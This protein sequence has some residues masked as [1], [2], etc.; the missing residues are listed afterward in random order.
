[1]TAP[2]VYLLAGEPS[3]DRLGAALI[4]GLRAEAPEVRIAG[5]GGREM[6]AA[7]L[8]TLFD[9]ADL[10]V[11]GYAE[12]LPRLPLILRRLRAATADVLARRPA[13]LV[14]IDAPAFGL[15]V[16]SRVRAADPSIRTVHY[17]APSVWAWR[18]R[19]A[20]Q[21]ARYVDHVLALLPFEP[22][23]MEAAGMSCD[24]VGHPVAAQR[25]ADAPERAAFRAARGIA[26]DAPL[27]LVAP[28]SRGGEVARLMPV[29]AEALGRL[30][31]RHAG[32]TAAVPVAETVAEPVARWAEALPVPAHLVRPEDGE[33]AKR[34]AFAACDAGIVASG[35]VAVELAAADCPHVSCYR[36]SWLSAAIAR[37][38][39]RVD[40]AHIVN[41]VLGRKAVPECLQERCTPEAIA[42]AV[43]PLLAPG[44]G[45]AQRAAF[46]EAMALLGREGPEPGLRAARSVLA[47]L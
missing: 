42:A 14:T 39:I 38:L 44:G 1:M 8:A 34:T 41:L 4:R 22:P 40:T 20:A 21:M 2:L 35:T 17:V 5:V 36:T 27:V 26:G 19:R 15:R 29:F 10:S 11:M 9:I 43:E 33:A 12:I 23:W 16:A 32:L 45:A 31:A 24:F 25:P 30:A 46:S 28:G 47:R 3:G 18:P 37:R 7:G 6:Q 13:V